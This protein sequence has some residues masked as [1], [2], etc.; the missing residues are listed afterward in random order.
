MTWVSVRDAETF[1]HYHDMRTLTPWEWQWLGQGA[2]NLI[3]PWGDAADPNLVPEFLSGREMPDPDDVDSHQAG[4]SWC[5][6]I[7]CFSIILLL[8]SVQHTI[9]P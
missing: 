4:A 3:Y 6:H 2:T 1:C 5:G 7:F 9:V 8:S